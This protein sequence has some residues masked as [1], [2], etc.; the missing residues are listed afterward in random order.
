VVNEIAGQL[1]ADIDGT[2][3]NVYLLGRGRVGGQQAEN[4]SQSDETN[5][6]SQ[7]QGQK[8]SM[9][10]LTEGATMPG[11]TPASSR[12]RRRAAYTPHQPP[13]TL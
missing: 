13:C 11:A 12:P 1:I 4:G 8:R 10:G 7:Q 3:I 9:A 5:T 2:H 6:E